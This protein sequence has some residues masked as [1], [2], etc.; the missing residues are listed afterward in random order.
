MSWFSNVSRFCFFG[1]FFGVFPVYAETIDIFQ[2]GGGYQFIDSSGNIK[3]TLSTLEGAKKAANLY[4]NAGAQVRWQSSL[5][6]TTTNTTGS[7]NSAASASSSTTSSTAKLPATTTKTSTA[8]V[9]TSSSS[10]LPATTTKTSTALVKTSSGSN[11]PATTSGG[12]GST[13]GGSN[14]GGG[15]SFCCV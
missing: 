5:P 2:T 1:L 3:G 6:A 14:A 12:E 11:L 10:N 15:G 7:Y 4:S 13:G 9:K 8:L